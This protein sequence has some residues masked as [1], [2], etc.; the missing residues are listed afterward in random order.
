MRHAGS[1][2]VTILLPPSPM[3]RY[4]HAWRRNLVTCKWYYCVDHRTVQSLAVVLVCGSLHCPVTWISIGVWVI[5]LSGHVHLVLVC[6]SLYH[7]VSYSCTCLWFILPW[8]TSSSIGVWV[9]VPS[10]LW[11]SVLLPCTFWL[12]GAS[13]SDQ[14]IRAQLSHFAVCTLSKNLLTFIVP[15]SKKS[16]CRLLRN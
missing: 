1:Q 9:I 14:H 4:C 7:L 10:M 5:V 11:P 16:T 6:G 2:S 8:V 12:V 15:T 13:T 3:I